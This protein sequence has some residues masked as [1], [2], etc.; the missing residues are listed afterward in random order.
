MCEVKQLLKRRPR[1]DLRRFRIL[2]FLT[3]FLL[4]PSQRAG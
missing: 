4:F 1:Y 3:G 2:G